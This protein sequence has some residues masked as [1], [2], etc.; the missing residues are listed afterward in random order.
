MES[1][2][3]S[4]P[5]PASHTGR[6]HVADAD[7]SLIR[8]RRRLTP[9]SNHK[10]HS[11]SPT[12]SAGSPLVVEVDSPESQPDITDEV[13]I[14]DDEGCSSN[15]VECFPWVTSFRNPEQAAAQFADIC[16]NFDSKEISLNDV[17][18]FVG[19][20]HDHVAVASSAPDYRSY[21]ENYMF[22]RHVGHCSEGLAT[23][24]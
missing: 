17:R 11:A 3:D 21:D 24:R 10:D 1:S 2:T 9:P 6:D 13:V 12:H 14:I 7:S 8:K 15:S 5:S 19:W 20:V 18:Q 4:A 16:W 23:R 22:W